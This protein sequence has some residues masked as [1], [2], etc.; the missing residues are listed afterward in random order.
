[1]NMGRVVLS[2]VY[3]YA[4]KCTPWFD[5]EKAFSQCYEIIFV[6]N[7]KLHL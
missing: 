3:W 5:G 4:Q 2:A 6:E 1:M 7:T